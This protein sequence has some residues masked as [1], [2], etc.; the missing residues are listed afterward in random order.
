MNELN[1][2]IRSVWIIEAV[3]LSVIIT[4]I[5]FVLLY[6]FT[7]GLIYLVS[8]LIGILS[9]I[10]GLIYQI[11]RYR[12][13]KYELRKDHVYLE[14]GVLVSVRKQVPYI[15]IQHIDSRRSII[16]R[17]TGLSTLVIYTAGSRG[18]DVSI[19]GLSSEKSDNLREKLKDLVLEDDDRWGDGV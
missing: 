1:P 3:L 8:I 17:I 5:S 7:T 16:E 10:S 14:Y 2:R 4:F 9:L 11:K 12:N 18:A 19:P 6:S 15:R 13:W